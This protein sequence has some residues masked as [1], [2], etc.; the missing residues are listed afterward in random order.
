[1]PVK[2]GEKTYLTKQES[3][4][5]ETSTA[6]R[7]LKADDRLKGLVKILPLLQPKALY[8]ELRAFYRSRRPFHC[9]IDNE[10]LPASDCRSFHELLAE[11]VDSM[12]DSNDGK[13]RSHAIVCQM[14][15]NERL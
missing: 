11:L 6:L 5:G 14:L 13:W 12:V 10:T 15:A 2:I 4:D 9:D 3:R 8:C 1:M 7:Q